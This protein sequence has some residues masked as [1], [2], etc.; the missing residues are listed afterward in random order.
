MNATDNAEFLRWKKA[1][2][3]Q[4]RSLPLANPVE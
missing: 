2:L 3:D 1:R 4:R